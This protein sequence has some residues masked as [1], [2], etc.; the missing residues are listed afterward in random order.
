[1][2]SLRRREDSR[3]TLARWGCTA[4]DRTVATRIGQQTRENTENKDKASGT[5]RQTTTDVW[6][7]RHNSDQRSQHREPASEW[8]MQ[9][10]TTFNRSTFGGQTGYNGWWC[11]VLLR[12]WRF[13]TGKSCSRKEIVVRDTMTVRETCTRYMAE[14]TNEGNV[15]LV[16]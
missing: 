1:M 7:R 13:G 4:Q 15:S 3:Q 16:L 2:P 9:R 8:C 12:F 14:K 10:R 6:P 11:G 5:K